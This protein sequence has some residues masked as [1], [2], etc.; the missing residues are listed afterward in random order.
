MLKTSTILLALALA[1]PELGEAQRQAP[2]AADIRACEQEA[3]AR[4]GAPPASPRS[5]PQTSQPTDD[6]RRDETTRP[7]KPTERP[8]EPAAS[9]I[10]PDASGRSA[11]LVAYEDCLRTRGL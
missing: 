6:P 4:A 10:I 7:P 9:P 3:K 1:A 8:G 11:Y 5:Q 2:S